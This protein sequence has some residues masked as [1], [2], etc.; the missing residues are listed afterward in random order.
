MSVTCDT[1]HCPI[2]PCWPLE[3]WPSG[4][5][6]RYMATELFS[7][8]SDRGEKCGVA[9]VALHAVANIDHSKSLWCIVCVCVCVCV[10]CVGYHSFLNVPAGE[11]LKMQPWTPYL[12]QSPKPLEWHIECKQ[13]PTHVQCTVHSACIHASCSNKTIFAA[14]GNQDN[15]L[16][17]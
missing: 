2:R 7:S 12:S 8:A 17:Q 3:Q 1:F 14:P 6:S 5:S 15:N 13:T 10:L 9:M 11:P 4:D 16:G